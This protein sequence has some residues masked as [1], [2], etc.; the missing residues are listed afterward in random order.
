LSSILYH[1]MSAAVALQD[2][3]PTTPAGG[4]AAGSTRTVLQ[5]IKEGGLIGAMLIFLS[6]VAVTLL[7][8]HLIQV[9]RSQLV[10]L[11]AATELQR[12][13]REN[14][15]QGA[16]RYCER[17]DSFLVRVF[18]SAMKRC[19]RSPFGFMEIRTALEES[20][21]R[22]ADRLN[23]SIELIGLI[24]AVAPMLGLLGTTIGMIGAFNSIGELEGA[25]RSRELAS[26]MSLA[27]V[28]TAEGLA[29]AIPASAA[30]SLLR[31]RLDRLISDA[32]EVVENLA[33]YIEN[34]GTGAPKAAAPRAAARPAAMPVG[35]VP[36]VRP[37]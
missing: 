5:Y 6:V 10:P 13:F 37:T 20:G 15:L 31:R 28:N 19:S 17:D 12:L 2:A 25:A 35:P 23:K 29:V 36:G 7:I 14:D 26:F 4:A 16:I 1:V 34:P 8:M 27:L 18:G 32:G 21:A 3:T 30:Y 11:E 33:V 22:E 9:R 24:A